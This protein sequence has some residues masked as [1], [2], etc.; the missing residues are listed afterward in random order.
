M[1]VVVVTAVALLLQQETVA[2]KPTRIY[3][4]VITILGECA[5][6]VCNL[7]VRTL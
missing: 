5:Q 6:R 1:E 3:A 4:L 2:V 7:K